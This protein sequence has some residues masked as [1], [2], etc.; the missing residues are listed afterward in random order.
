MTALQAELLAALA[1]P[2][3]R[4]LLREIARE[5][6]AAALAQLPGPSSPDDLIDV[7]E[8]ARLRGCSLAAA[9]KLVQRGRL[10]VVRAGRTVRVRRRDALGGG[11]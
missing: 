11:R 1:S 4:Q 2:E 5:G 7:A 8:L 10:P 6:A 3:G 9:R